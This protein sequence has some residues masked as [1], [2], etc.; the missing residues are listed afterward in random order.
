M[1][2]EAL[3]TGGEVPA[4]LPTMT[5]VIPTY[6]QKDYLRETIDSCLN[7]DYE[8]L[9]LVVV[10]DCSTDGTEE[11][12]KAYGG[13]H[14]V[15]YVRNKTNL[16][17][18]N[19]THKLFYEY[20][21]TQY[22]MVLNHDDY[23]VKT[24][25]VTLAI[26]LLE[27]HPQVAFVWAN[28]Y[29]K[30]QSTG[31]M[32]KTAHQ[33]NPVTRGLDYFLGYELPIYPHITGFLTTVFRTEMLKHT[34]FGR[35]NTKSKDSFFYLKLMLQ[36]DVGFIQAPVAVYRYHMESLSYNMPSDLDASTIEAYVKLKNEV[37]AQKLFPEEKMAVWLNNRIFTYIYWRI[38]SLWDCGMHGEA[39]DL[40]EGM[41]ET[42]P[43]VHREILKRWNALRGTNRGV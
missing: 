42:Y 22:A 43:G 10:D 24:D 17:P 13:N 27:C 19:N 1:R 11:M 5:I 37:T 12:M 25:Y 4:E 14:K 32:R 20:P 6:N 3:H 15:H 26:K 9:K 35:E 16:G 28:C 2:E 23:L 33:L 29:Q 39:L 7:Q 34:D 18:G 30:V 36:G 38:T 31:A 40:L 41:T 21:D 8:N